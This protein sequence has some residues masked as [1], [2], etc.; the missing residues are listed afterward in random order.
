[1]KKK[2]LSLL[3]LPVMASGCFAGCALGDRGGADLGEL[4]DYGY[5]HRY[6]ETVKLSI[7]QLVD[8]QNSYFGDEYVGMNAV[9][10]LWNETLNADLRVKFSGSSTDISTSVKNNMYDD[11]LP[12]ITPCS[13]VM[14]D[15]LYEQEMLRDLTPYYEKY[16]SPHLRQIL[17][18]N[19]IDPTF[20][21]WT[22]EEKESR[23]VQNVLAS[24]YKGES[25]Y[26]IPMLI[27]AYSYL[28]YVYIRTDWLKALA[29]KDFNDES[30]FKELMPKS[31]T[32]LIELAYRFKNEIKDLTGYR[33]SVYP[34]YVNEENFLYQLFGATHAY[35]EQDDNGDWYYTTHRP[36]M[37]TALNGVRQLIA[38][39]IYDARYFSETSNASQVV[40]N[41]GCGIYIGRFWQPLQEINDT[42]MS[43]EG[44][45]WEVDVLYDAQG[46]IM[47]PYSRPN[48]QLYYVVSDKCK[49]PEALF[50]MLNHIV[51]GCFDINAPYS[52]ALSELML[53]PKYA[54]CSGDMWEWA[55]IVFDAPD[56]NFYSSR[57][58]LAALDGE[59]DKEGMMASSY[60]V[61]NCIDGWRKNPNPK[62]NNYNWIYNKIYAEVEPIVKKYDGRIN[63]GGYHGTATEQMVAKAATISNYQQTTM[64]QFMTKST[65]I[66]QSE[67]DDF[68]TRHRNLG[69]KAILDE[70][71]TYYRDTWKKNA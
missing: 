9:Y 37:L 33:N 4:P 28:P 39:G 68:I 13:E 15:E 66:T 26:A 12:D 31:S 17:E 49:H 6:D 46:E 34:L 2:A 19:T 60:F 57:E 38:D 24:S 67:F 36:E 5:F 16:A 62:T 55:P 23:K 3:L 7:G 42:V 25:L 59:G 58:V 71:D 14:L 45:D 52:K 56:K 40:K 11:D 63:Y 61:Y 70:L 10:D 21:S 53:D 29:Q 8:K 69:I 32:E 18:Y 51:E 47:R 20:D 27:D 64:L 50:F 65:P 54:S 43:I 30:R 22:A 44:A 35:Y 1:M 41:G 48:I